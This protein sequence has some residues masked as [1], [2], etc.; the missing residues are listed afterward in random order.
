MKARAYTDET[1]SQT[2]FELASWKSC[3]KNSGKITWMLYTFSHYNEKRWTDNLTGLLFRW[4][5]LIVS[6][7]DHKWKLHDIQKQQL[8]MIDFACIT[9]K[10]NSV[11]WST[12]LLVFK[13][14]GSKSKWHS[15]NSLTCRYRGGKHNWRWVVVSFPRIDLHTG[16]EK[17]TFCS[18]N[19]PFQN[20][21]EWNVDCGEELWTIEWN[22]SVHTQ[23]KMLEN[24]PYS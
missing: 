23:Y 3:A 7:Y 9:S 15:I 8:N 20:Q 11:H 16:D 6:K 21:S 22:S 24:R 5:K 17:V 12:H 10:V 2:W 18:R 1:F 19:F 4:E 13:H 14:S